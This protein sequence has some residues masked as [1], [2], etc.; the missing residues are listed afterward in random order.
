[1]RIKWIDFLF[2]SF[3][4]V[5]DSSV[6][7][8]KENGWLVRLVMFVVDS[9]VRIG[10]WGANC[11]GEIISLEHGYLSNALNLRHRLKI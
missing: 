5:L 1:M 6:K 8:I 7:E 3:D 11:D 10:R 9:I 2:C 4:F